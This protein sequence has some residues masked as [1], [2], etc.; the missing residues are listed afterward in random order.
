MKLRMTM[1]IS[2]N[3]PDIKTLIDLTAGLIGIAFDEIA[4]VGKDSGTPDDL[5]AIDG[6]GPA[7]AGRLNEAGIT[8]FSQLAEL[9][10]EEIRDYMKLSESQGDPESWLEQA[11]KLS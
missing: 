2:Q 11:Q 5:T 3:L 7:Y 10:V 4:G 9:S 8:T 6:I 1:E